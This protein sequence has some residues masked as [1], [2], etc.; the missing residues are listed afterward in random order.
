MS[1][2]KATRSVHG[3]GKRPARQRKPPRPKLDWVSTVHD[4]TVHQA[5]PEEL[6]RRHEL[7][8]SRHQE[9]AQRELRQRV[10]RTSGA[11]SE[12]DRLQDVL[13]KSD[14]MM[15]MVKDLFGDAPPRQTGFPSVTMAL[16]CEPASEPVLLLDPSGTGGHG[17]E[18]L[19]R[20]VAVSRCPVQDLCHGRPLS[21]DAPGVS[22]SCPQSPSVPQC[23]LNATPVVQKLLPQVPPDKDDPTASLVSCVLNMGPVSPTPGKRTSR[24][25]CANFSRLSSSD[26]RSSSGGCSS[27][28]VLQAR[29]K[30][31]ELQLDSLGPSASRASEDQ[32]GDATLS[33]FST[34]LVAILGRLVQHLCR[35][36]EEVQ[37]EVTIRRRLEEQLGEQQ[38]LIDALTAESLLLHRDNTTLQK[39]VKDLDKR[40]G[41]LV[42]AL[43]ERG[44]MG[45][46]AE[47]RTC[48]HGREDTC[49]D[50]HR[51]QLS[52]AVSPE[53]DLREVSSPFPAVLLSPPRQTDSCSSHTEVA[54]GELL[55]YQAT[56]SV[57]C[58]EVVEYD[59]SMASSCSFMS[60]PCH[61]FAHSSTSKL[62]PVPLQLRQASQQNPLM[63]APSVAGRTAQRPAQE[64][65][66]VEQQLLELNRRSVEARSRLLLLIEEQRQ[67]IG[68]GVSPCISPIP[69]ARPPG[70]STLLPVPEAEP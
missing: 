14:H 68:G 35:S 61:G 27:L 6:S 15:A 43:E 49:T 69:S 18:P 52:S 5:T 26:M 44:R 2:R 56:S 39:H 45:P 66:S 31:M 54:I 24:G 55:Q 11:S 67:A 36:H 7:H 70:V 25:Q 63:P 9:S 37:K 40:L 57:G 4:L 1:F 50:A 3:P 34:A 62:D 32:Q 48:L 41:T 21:P 20:D 33:G 30:K 8:R 13:A 28:E 59:E 17:L 60:L 51:L 65:H 10:L 12:Q 47:P 42:L 53:K 46:E 22:L 23:A 19:A 16:D 58:Q 29:L 38:Q 64:G